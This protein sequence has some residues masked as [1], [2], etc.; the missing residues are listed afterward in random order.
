MEISMNSMFAMANF[1]PMLVAVL[2]A[3]IVS[4]TIHEFS[5]ALVAYIGG[6]KS[7]RE[8]GYL[9]LDPTK[10]IDPVMSLLIPAVVLLMGGFPLPGAA[11]PVDRSL[12]RSDKW[13]KLV[14][15]AGPASNFVLFL[16]LA[17]IL[18][19]VFGLTNGIASEQP[20]WILFLGAMA[21]LNL[22]AVFLNLIPIPPLDGFGIIEHQFDLQTREVM[23]RNS[24][25][26]LGGLFL[27]FWVFDW[28]FLA[29]NYMIG[30]V[31]SGLG[32]DF[33]FFFECFI[34]VMTGTI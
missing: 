29:L 5:H 20:N 27:A 10:F 12:L 21:Y 31:M 2:L 22:F 7:M 23:H 24:Y 3:W 9:T 28:P 16:L 19:P 14:S 8:R 33:S 13:E 4:V 18:H 25:V 34:I 1:S 11:V 30:S 6:D 32:F 15:A 26:F 17:A